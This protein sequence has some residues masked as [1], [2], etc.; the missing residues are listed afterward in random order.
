MLTSV[1]PSQKTR[2]KRR[3]QG[4]GSQAGRWR[5][6]EGERKEKYARTRYRGICS[7]SCLGKLFCSTLNMRL[8][9]FSNNLK[10]LHRSQIGFFPGHRASDHI[11]TLRTLIRLIKLQRHGKSE[12]IQIMSWWFYFHKEDSNEIENLHVTKTER[13]Q[14]QPFWIQ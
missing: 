5:C 12:A 3:D 7:R 14:T 2:V 13:N 11:F 1:D 10:I 6:G 4:C 8:L 9:N